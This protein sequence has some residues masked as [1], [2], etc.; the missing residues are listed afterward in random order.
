MM[1]EEISEERLQARRRKTVQ[2]AALIADSKIPKE[3]DLQSREVFQCGHA[4]PIKC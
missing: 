2:W 3:P 4:L 1:Q